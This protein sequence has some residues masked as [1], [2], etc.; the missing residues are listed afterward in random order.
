MGYVDRCCPEAL[1]VKGPA[2]VS[3]GAEITIID[4]VSYCGWRCRCSIERC[5]G[6]ATASAPRSGTQGHIVYLCRK[7][8][9]LVERY[10]CISRDLIHICLVVSA[11]YGDALGALISGCNPQAYEATVPLAS[12]CHYGIC[13]A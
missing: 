3:A 8:D 7:S 13:A 12:P 1:A 9:V 5:N 4:E 2:C 6:I 11:F 10:A